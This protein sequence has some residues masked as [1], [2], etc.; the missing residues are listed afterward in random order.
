MSEDQAPNLLRLMEAIQALSEKIDRLSHI[1]E[2]VL[3]MAGEELS[4][5]MG[6]AQGNA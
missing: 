1:A 5:A 6:D 4:D 2:A 3:T